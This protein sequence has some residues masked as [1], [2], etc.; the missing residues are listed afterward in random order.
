MRQPSAMTFESPSD[1]TA[2]ARLDPRVAVI[3]DE[4]S[5]QASAG[6]SAA[7]SQATT[8]IMEAL[9][10][11]GMEPVELYLRPN[12]SAQWLTKL[13]DGEFDLAFNL[14]ETVFGL[15]R[16]EHLAA[17][18]VELLGLPMTGAPSSS[19]LLCLNKDRCSAI[20]RAH[21][22]TVPDWLLV[23]AK[24]PLPEVW[25]RFPAIVKPAAEDASNGVHSSSV[26]RD[27]EGLFDRVRYVRDNWGEVLI[28]SYIEGREINLAIVGDCLLPPA[29]I[30]FSTL[31][32]GSAPIVSFE[33][34]WYDDSPEFAGTVPVCPAE[35]P[36]DQT[37]Q[38]Q[39]LAAQAWTL[40]EGKGYGRVDVRLTPDG[41]PYVIDVNP[42][43]DL[44]IDAG[45]AR[46]ARVAGWSYEE[47]V[48]KIVQVAIEPD[49]H[50]VTRWKILEPQIAVGGAT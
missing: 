28:Q 34:K 3:L 33:A 25:D 10:A 24:D 39:M 6:D 35:L 7:P 13:I 27:K 29:E 38:L 48:A 5:E 18:A 49:E 11:L 47:L 26:V 46:Q 8:N 40:L 21:D 22:I 41:S 4:L 42:N 17:S 36:D 30:D 23:S 1:R 43:P 9:G 45:L 14:C 2:N 15:A 37:E 50:V 20:L 32:E 44:S 12:E 19:L 31:P 16:G